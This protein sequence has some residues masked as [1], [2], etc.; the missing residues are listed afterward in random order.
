MSAFNPLVKKTV[1]RWNF[2]YRLLSI[3]VCKNVL[4][5]SYKIQAPNQQNT[6]M[7]L[8]LTIFHSLLLKH[9]YYWNA[10]PKSIFLLQRPCYI[11]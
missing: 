4:S 3:A 11:C 1:N 7:L 6:H 5:F 8:K 9:N 2:S 10:D